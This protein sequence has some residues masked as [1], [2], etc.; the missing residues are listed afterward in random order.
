MDLLG[1][2]TTAAV[3]K[4]APS[5]PGFSAGMPLFGH[6][7]ANS[8]HFSSKGSFLVCPSELR[9]TLDQGPLWENPTMIGHFLE[10]VCGIIEKPK[11]L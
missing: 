3:Q 11:V 8:D 6:P 4:R 2:S 1:C 5:S 9:T 10:T 7:S